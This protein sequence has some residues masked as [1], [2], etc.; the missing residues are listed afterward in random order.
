MAH[1]L[2]ALGIGAFGASVV[3][4]ATLRREACAR[5]AQQA[6]RGLL[7]EAFQA[8]EVSPS[9]GETQRR[10]AGP[11][12][13]AGHGSRDLGNEAVTGLATPEAV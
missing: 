5:E 7:H 8:L 13:Q 2:V 9:H 10:E 3:R 4:D 6:F 1:G 11:P 12:S